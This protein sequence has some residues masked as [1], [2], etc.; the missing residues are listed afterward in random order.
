MSR[1]APRNGGGAP[2][3]SPSPREDEPMRPPRGGRG[4]MLPPLIEPAFMGVGSCA[5][6]YIE[7]SQINKREEKQI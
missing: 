5:V 2:L 3:A 1:C 7:M 4:R 6:T